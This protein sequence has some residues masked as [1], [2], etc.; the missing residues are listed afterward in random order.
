MPDMIQYLSTADIYTP[1]FFRSFIA[2]F[3]LPDIATPILKTFTTD[4]E[5]MQ[6]RRHHIIHDRAWSSA[7][8]FLY[9][10]ESR[11]S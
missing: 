1:S 2:P 3:C 9:C 7:F 10:S 8:S 4:V 5:R 6:R 11:L